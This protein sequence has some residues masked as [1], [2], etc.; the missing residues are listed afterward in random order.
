MHIYICRWS[1]IYKIKGVP[2]SRH[3]NSPLTHCPC[4]QG[5]Y[6]TKKKN[7]KAGQSER[8]RWPGEAL[9][10]EAWTGDGF[11]WAWPWFAVAQHE[12]R[13]PELQ[14]R[15]LPVCLA[16]VALRRFVTNEMK[17]IQLN[18]NLRHSQKAQPAAN[19]KRAKKN[20]SNKNRTEQQTE[21]IKIIKNSR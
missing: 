17:C 9:A 15:N 1:M 7:L 10:A 11:V 18:K 13:M 8:Q 16:N 21:I 19:K 6:Y 3:R 14:L 4:I 5:I 20:N 12:K 2:F